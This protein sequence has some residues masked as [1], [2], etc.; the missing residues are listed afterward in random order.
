MAWQPT[1][2]KKKEKNS[3]PLPWLGSYDL[4]QFRFLFIF[5]YPKTN[6]T[7]VKIYHWRN[8]IGGISKKLKWYITFLMIFWIN[9]GL[10]QFL[11]FLIR[12]AFLIAHHKKVQSRTY[13]HSGR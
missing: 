7:I 12:W 6:L 3:S 1:P 2:K 8:M 5:K 13:F 4:A 11:F 9:R 10:P